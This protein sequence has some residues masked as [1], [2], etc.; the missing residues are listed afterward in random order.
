V[1]FARLTLPR[2]ID[3]A[4]SPRSIQ[5]ASDPV[6]LDEQA[7][8][9]APASVAA[10]VSL[11][12]ALQVGNGL[13]DPSAIVFLAV[14]LLLLVAAVFVRRPDRFHTSDARIVP[15]LAGTGL[16]LQ[17]LQLSTSPPGEALRADPFF[18]GAFTWGL[19]ALGLLGAAIV[20]RAARL[21]RLWLV[22]LFVAVHAAM[23]VLVIRYSQGPPFI[24]VDVFQRDSV[25]ALL[26]G[27]NPYGITFPNIYRDDLFYGPGASIDGRLQF[28]FPYF[29]LSLLLVVPAEVLAGDHRYA[30]LA[31]IEGAALL[32]ATSRARGFG[33]IAAVLFLTTP[34][35][36]F[37]VEQSWTEPFVVLGL[38]AVVFAAC[39]NERLVPWLFGLFLALKQYLVFALP[40]G[41]WLLHRRRGAAETLR[42]L[43]KAALI[44]AAITLPFV[45]WSPEAFIR[46]V[47]T[48]QFHQPFRGESL[49]FLSWWARRGHGAPSA[50]VAFLVASVMAGVSAWRL[51]R[52]PAAFATALAVTFLSF[53]AFNKQ[54]FCNYYF[55]VIGALSVGI[56]STSDVAAS[57]TRHEDAS[58]N[59]PVA[60][61]DRERSWVAVAALV[62]VCLVPLL[63][64]GDAPFI[65]DEPLLIAAAANA[66]DAGQLAAT[67]LLG[68]FGF[69][70]GPV[71]TWMYQALL[72]LSHDLV[73]VA[74][75]HAAIVVGATA[76]A[77]WW[78]S[79]ALGLWASF[80][81]V[82]LLSPYF[83]FYARVLWDN[84]LLI[85][86]GGLALA[87]YAAHLQSGSRPGL[88]VSVAAMLLM[89]LVHLMAAAFVIPL[90]AHMVVFRWRSLRAQRASLATI[91]AGIGIMAWP[92]LRFLAASHTPGAGSTGGIDGYVFPL[93][94]GRILSA[95]ELRYFYGPGPLVGPVMHTADTISSLAYA[96]VWG[97]LVVA[98][99]AVVVAMRTRRW[100][101]RAHVAGIAV[102][103]LACQVVLDGVT[104]KFEHP[105]YYN[106][107][108]I[109]FALLA[110]LAVDWLAT[111][112][113]IIRHA[114]PLATGVLA[115]TLLVSVGTLAL[116][117]HASS[118]T[119]EVYGPTLSN[120]QRVARQLGE[121]SASSRIVTRVFP[122]VAY[123]HALGTLQQLNA[124]RYP[125]QTYGDLEIRYAS[126]DPRSGAIELV[127]H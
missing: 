81:P 83:W 126:P 109:V 67:G 44:G 94:G 25:A 74:A 114:A 46:S 119:R 102:A 33:A 3:D 58:S 15:L 11:G 122:Y 69:T 116:R 89:P 42:F 14:A 5:T 18:R 50:A 6:A 19:A 88:R 124:R 63:W 26:K 66:N 117:L 73:V 105:Q 118:G 80:A 36:F 87:G 29:P 111:R 90:A 93:L 123:P 7:H 24:D 23:G 106:G 103:A 110:W 72:A 70:Y 76:I 82:P 40:A 79:R 47:V 115:A 84:P 91:V 92:Y 34:R 68:T 52:T 20:G 39:R 125:S 60:P 100:T 17:I 75:L 108:W 78:L 55:F 71:P 96:L 12:A 95:R 54:A 16:I 101:A 120:Q 43:G 77:L 9:L 62:A 35:V 112:G 113:S 53:F 8:W 13:L 127:V 104:G 27:I 56:A 98:V 22:V 28:G 86:L 1:R 10:A 2:G 4:A 41:I 59:R 97:G 21:P 107:T 38:A 32:M 30:A 51:P 99:G 48:L 121:Y 61:R 31:A 49:S 64:P 65:N 57:A 45:L 37:V 85:P